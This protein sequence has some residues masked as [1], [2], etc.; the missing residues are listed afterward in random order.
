MLDHAR[1]GDLAVLG[2]VADQ[3]DGRAVVLGQPYQFGGAGADLGDG[4]WPGLVGVGP[5]GLDG[6]DDDDVELVALQRRQD[7][8]QRR[9]R[10]QRHGGVGHA[11]AFGA[12]AD[13]FNG[14]FARDIGDAGAVARR[15]GRDLQQQGRLAHAGVAAQQDGRARHH[16][17]AADAVE[18]GHAGDDARR[19]GRVGLQGLE[20][21]TAPARHRGRLHR[22]GG[23]RFR[24]L[25]QAVPLAAGRALPRP[26]GMNR[27][28]GLTDI[29]K[30]V[31]RHDPDLAGIAARA[32][33]HA[34][35]CDRL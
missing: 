14:F 26:F 16:A 30:G 4:A 18:L 8:A 34:R 13:L 25:G 22:A 3:D 11:H 6:I 31:A 24:L 2:D 21:Q 17:A 33:G 15:L 12:G 7:F 9:G 1:P 32:R 20:R 5:Q 19:L 10:G 35:G 28:A 23:R 29:E 27:P